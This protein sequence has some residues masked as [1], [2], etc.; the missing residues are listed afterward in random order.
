MTVVLVEDNRRIADLYVDALADLG[1]AARSF[2]DGESFLGALPMLGADLLIL[3]RHLPGID[4]LEVA[5]RVRA[6]R[7]GLPILM[8]SANPPN[9][10]SV[11]ATVDRVLGKP[12][13]IEQFS[14]AVTALLERQ[15]RGAG[16]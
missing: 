2:R 16:T 8:I 11:A 9:Q 5:R 3:D 7:P 14:D 15:D 1:H 10:A 4:G 12:C 6:L 13:M